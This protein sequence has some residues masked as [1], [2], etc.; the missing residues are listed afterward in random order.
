M[1]EP[2]ASAPFVEVCSRDQGYGAFRGFETSTAHTVPCSE[3]GCVQITPAEEV[4]DAGCA[5]SGASCRAVVIR[6][7]LVTTG[8]AA[9]RA[10]Q[11]LLDAGTSEFAE[12]SDGC[13]L[14]LFDY[15]IHY[16]AHDILDVSFRSSGQG[17]YPSANMSHVT[18]DLQTGTRITAQNAF[19]PARLP[20][21]LTLLRSKV[22]AA[23]QR[24]ALEIPEVFHDQEEPTITVEDV[25]HF[26]VQGTGIVF[27]Y[28]FGF[29]HVIAAATPDNEYAL[30]KAALRR[31]IQPDG[32]LAWMLESTR[33]PSK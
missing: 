25:G 16:D 13:W 21:L 24:K 5:D 18:I 7:E 14:A 22:H 10:T 15:T 29:P 27:I 11:R 33:A 6:P 30:P 9:N 23:W 31:F 3:P 19:R 17:A 12:L 8:S 2:D 32:P 28:D 1:A 26:V 4:A 20:E